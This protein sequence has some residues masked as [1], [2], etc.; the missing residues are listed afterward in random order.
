TDV[1]LPFGKPFNGND[2]V[3]VT[4]S[5][6]FDAVTSNKTTTTTENGADPESVTEVIHEST[7]LNL[8]NAVEYPQIRELYFFNITT[9]V[10]ASLL[11]DP[12]FTKY[13]AKVGD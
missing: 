3:K 4:I 11:K 8:L 13:L 12:N 5:T 9:G 6:Y 10:V 7:S 2:I 1:I